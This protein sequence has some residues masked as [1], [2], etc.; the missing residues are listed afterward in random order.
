MASIAANQTSAPARAELLERAA[1]LLPVLRERA[2]HTE[3]LRRLP[4]ETVHDLVASQLIRIGVPRRY[5]GL[6]V[7]YDA[8]AEIAWLL[9]RACG[10]SAWCYALWTVHAFLAGYWPRRAQEE[11]FGSGPDVLASSSF[12]PVGKQAMPV[13]GGYRIS[14]CWQFSSGCDAAS[15]AELG[16]TTPAG[17]I[18]M[19]VPRSDYEIVD[20][21]FVAGLCGSGS[22]DL[23]IADAFVPDYRTLSPDSAG[24][25][26]WSGWE[27][28]QQGRYHVPLR[29]L[30][31]WDLQAPLVGMAQ[32]C[33]DEFI[34]NARQRSGPRG[35]AADAPYL[36]IR[37]AESCAELDAAR[38]L[39]LADMREMLER[40]GRCDP[41]TDVDRAR[42]QR[43]RAFIADLSVRA[44]NRLY[45]ASG[46]H[47]IFQ[48]EPMQRMFRD[49]HAATHRETML[50][51]A[52]GETFGRLLLTADSE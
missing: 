14:G 15:W 12:N 34:R 37:V 48:S 16:A 30:I 47:A 24:N 21:W 25:G 4:D 36:Q 49:V 6:S 1:A 41:F 32:G 51:D 52:A 7:E 3:A 38:A 17:V 5:G 45:D 46:G 20:N 9:G 19:L 23:V 8:M 13:A 29:S 40:G 11:F 18:W 33:V 39:L 22:K 44:A 26:D 50:L 10:A 35:R 2:A 31:G 28:H 43:D 27:L 42:Y